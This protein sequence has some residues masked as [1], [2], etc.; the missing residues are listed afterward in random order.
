MAFLEATFPR[1]AFLRPHARAALGALLRALMVAFGTL[2]LS[3]WIL[4]VNNWMQTP[5][6]CEVVDGRFFKDWQAQARRQRQP[7]LYR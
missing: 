6:G 5:V 3:F 1:S 2:L 7:V 4:P